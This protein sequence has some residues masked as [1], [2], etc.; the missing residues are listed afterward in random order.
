MSYR[1][2]RK[3]LKCLSCF[4]VFDNHSTAGSLTLCWVP[5]AEEEPGMGEARTDEAIHMGIGENKEQGLRT[6]WKLFV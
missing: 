6:L 2:L 1:A 5:A 3:C 4:G